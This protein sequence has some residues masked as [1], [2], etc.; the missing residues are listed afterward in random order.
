MSCGRVP[1]KSLGRRPSFRPSTA[2][3]PASLPAC[4][5]FIWFWSSILDT[6]LR[7]YDPPADRT[8][9]TGTNTYTTLIHPSIHPRVHTFRGCDTWLRACGNIHTYLPRYI[10]THTYICAYVHTNTHTHT[11]LSMSSEPDQR[12]H[13]LF[14][15]AGPPVQAVGSATGAAGIYGLTPVGCLSETSSPCR[16]AQDPH[17]QSHAINKGSIKAPAFALPLAS[18]TGSPTHTLKRFG[19]PGTLVPPNLSSES[20]RLRWLR[21]QSPICTL[22]ARTQHDPG[23]PAPVARLVAVSACHS[24]S[25]PVDRKAPVLV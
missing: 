5:Q 9:G 14:W 2:S 6:D 20:D 25:R 21:L 23:P 10:H 22:Q 11:H 19:F 17:P 7:S 18:R 12:H 16:T 24:L 8:P 4:Q 3:L 1:E 13:A 15:N